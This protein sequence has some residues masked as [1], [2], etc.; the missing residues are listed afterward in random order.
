[1]P[2]YLKVKVAT[3]P[4]HTFSESANAVNIPGKRF[5]DEYWFAIA[6]KKFVHILSKQS[7]CVPVIMLIINWWRVSMSVFTT[8]TYVCV[9]YCVYLC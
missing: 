5:K 9:W 2:K 8:C 4:H 6:N 7:I 3:E 1:M